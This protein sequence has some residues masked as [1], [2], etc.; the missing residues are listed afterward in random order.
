L[1]EQTGGFLSALN[2]G[3]LTWAG[4]VSIILGIMGNLIASYIWDIKS[5]RTLP[6]APPMS[7]TRFVG[8]VISLILAILAMFIMGWAMGSKIGSSVVVATS[9][10]LIGF[11]TALLLDRFKW[12]RQRFGGDSLTDSITLGLLGFVY[13]FF[14]LAV[15]GWVFRASLT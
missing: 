10:L 14:V 6:P 9:V 3:L 13:S 15:L 1:G 12:V 5:T 7:G 2:S 4:I 8:Y 11:P